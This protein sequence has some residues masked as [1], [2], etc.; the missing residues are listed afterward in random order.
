MTGERQGTTREPFKR[1]QE[2]IDRESAEIARKIKD[3]WVVSYL[4]NPPQLIPPEQPSPPQ[5]THHPKP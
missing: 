1:T 2:Q 5:S 3:G 4:T